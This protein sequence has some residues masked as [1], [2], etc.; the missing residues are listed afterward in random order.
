[1]RPVPVAGVPSASHA[2]PSPRRCAAYHLYEIA[3]AG[4][5]YQIRRRVRAWDPALGRFTA[6]GPESGEPIAS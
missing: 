2:G 3:G 4:G 5:R 1:V 6:R